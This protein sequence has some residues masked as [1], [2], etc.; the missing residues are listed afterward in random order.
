MWRR[1]VGGSVVAADVVGRGACAGRVDAGY[2][3]S[4]KGKEPARADVAGIVTGSTAES[5]RGREGVWSG[6]WA[7]IPAAHLSRRFP[8]AAGGSACQ[9]H[10]RASA[11]RRGGPGGCR[12]ADEQSGE[13]SRKRAGSVEGRAS[14]STIGEGARPKTEEG[15]VSASTIGEGASARSAEKGASASTIG[16]A[17]RA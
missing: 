1:A 16:E 9:D 5:R 14:A 13:G 12:A 4:S 15:R 8:A 3:R 10:P 11:G 2:G 6:H 17:A 7:P